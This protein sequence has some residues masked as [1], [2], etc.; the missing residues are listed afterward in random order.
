MHWPQGLLMTHRAGGCPFPRGFQGARRTAGEP[1]PRSPGPVCPVSLHLFASYPPCLSLLAV[2]PWGMVWLTILEQRFC[3]LNSDPECPSQVPWDS[4]TE[5]IRSG[6][7]N[8][9]SVDRV[10]P[11]RSSRP[12]LEQSHQSHEPWLISLLRTKSLF[13]AKFPTEKRTLARPG[14][15]GLGTALTAATY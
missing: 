5:T 1:H 3:A 10:P 11:I 15:G 13:K 8:T 12:F 6:Q 4:V 14:L 9:H 7:R 2:A